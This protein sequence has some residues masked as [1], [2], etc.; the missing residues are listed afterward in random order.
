MARRKGGRGGRGGGGSGGDELEASK[1]LVDA[2]GKLGDTVGDAV[3]GLASFGKHLVEGAAE[4]KRAQAAFEH[5]QST[6]AFPEAQS[7]AAQY[8]PSLVPGLDAVRRNLGEV[9]A[10]GQASARLEGF[11]AKA[12]EAGVPVDKSFLGELVNPLLRQA[13]AGEHARQDAADVMHSVTGGTGI[14]DGLLEGIRKI[15]EGASQNGGTTKAIHDWLGGGGG[16][17]R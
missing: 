13:Q 4:V 8:A 16:S 1:R 11:A 12:A 10:E 17:V 15:A 2:F 9:S 6:Y 5:L 7:L 3:D 14:L